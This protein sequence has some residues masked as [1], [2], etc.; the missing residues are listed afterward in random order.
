MYFHDRQLTGI[1]TSPGGNQI[2]PR[3]SQRFSIP[4]VCVP[5]SVFRP[6]TQT[7]SASHIGL[8]QAK[9]HPYE[10]LSRR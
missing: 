4:T 2:V 6:E 1:E 10:L 7:Q 3:P 9:F 8:T 5:A